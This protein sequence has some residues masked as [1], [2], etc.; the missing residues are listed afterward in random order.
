MY[1]MYSKK[2]RQKKGQNS[3]QYG[4]LQKRYSKFA[5]EYVCLYENLVRKCGKSILIV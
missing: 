1:I 5:I 3:Y 2:V 4:T